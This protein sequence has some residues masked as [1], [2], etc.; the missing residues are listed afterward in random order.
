[1]SLLPLHVS[2]NVFHG[3]DP[4]EVEVDK[5]N[6]RAWLDTALLLQTDS[7]LF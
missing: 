2:Q 5:Q 3:Y 1:M 6:L 7:N 4:Y